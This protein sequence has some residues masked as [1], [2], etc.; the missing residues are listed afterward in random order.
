M[1]GRVQ[2]TL[3]DP[4]TA[5]PIA[6][7]SRRDVLQTAAAVGLSAAAPAAMGAQAAQA[8]SPAEG[9]GN[10]KPN[11]L[12][13]FPDQ[14]RYNA[15][16]H[17]GMQSAHTPTIDR[18]AAEGTRFTSTW[19]QAPI[20]RPA[21]LSLITG[22]Y[23]HQHRHLYN[24]TFGD[25]NNKLPTMMQSLQREG[26]VTATFGKTDYRVPDWLAKGGLLGLKDQRYDNRESYPFLRSFGWDVVHDDEGRNRNA[27]E[28]YS[29]EYVDFLKENGWLEMFQW[30]VRDTRDESA[31]RGSKWKPLVS[32]LPKEAENTCFTANQV[33]DFLQKH[34]PAKPFFIHFGPHSPH[35]PM[36]ADPEWAAYYIDKPVTLG[37]R[38]LP[39]PINEQWRKWLETWLRD[40]DYPTLTDD[41]TRAGMRMYLGMCSLVDEKLGEIVALLEKRSMM[42][43]TWIVMASDHGEMLGD[44]YFM[45]KM[46]FY[47]GSVQIPG[48]IRPPRKPAQA[49]VDLPVETIDLT[50]SI[51]DIAGAD[52][53]PNSRGASLLP[54]M[55][56][57]AH[58]KKAVFSETGD[59]KATQYMVA[60]RTADY[61]YT[62]EWKSKTPCEFFDLKNDPE[63]AKNRVNDASM[64]ARIDEH[65]GLITDHLKDAQI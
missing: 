42:D 33:I 9:H 1:T 46:T 61:R 27:V 10:K 62:L 21:R 40:S 31:E 17:A 5:K 8:K 18:L 25:F 29:S 28:N 45:G 43:N 4:E 59:G 55:N 34:D 24:L 23:V 49:Q 56:G 52:P 13:V 41:M 12:F 2:D 16:G 11:I 60:V 3:C 50:A 30:Q 51:L 20:C 7:M 58:D 38:V 19:T 57:K 44:Y 37:P 6:E 22:L 53:L 26:Y 54:V 32:L 15:F 64:K 39:E 63:E 65:H 14:W 47:K 48:I 35:L 36:I